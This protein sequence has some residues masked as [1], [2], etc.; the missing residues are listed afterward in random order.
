MLLGVP[1]GADC[2]EHAAALNALLDACGG[3][4]GNDSHVTC[5]TRVLLPGYSFLDS[6]CTRTLAVSL[7]VDSV[8]ETYTEVYLCVRLDH[9]VDTQAHR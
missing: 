5:T 4:S 2:T 8:I 7:G 9:T 3:S 1:S 6:G